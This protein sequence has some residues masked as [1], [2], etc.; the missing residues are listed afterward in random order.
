MFAVIESGGKQHTVSEG[1]EL[2]VE[3]LTAAQDETIEFDKVL[4]I[5]NGSDS[6]IGSPFV[7]NAKVTAKLITHGKR[8]KIKVFKM[9]RR[10]GYKRTYGHR[11]NFTQ[12][13]IESIIF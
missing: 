9:K 13:K 8:D 5:S 7:E 10:Q 12:I 3:L 11:Q 4:M 2:K 1:D 6:K